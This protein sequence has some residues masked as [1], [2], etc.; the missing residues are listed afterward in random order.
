MAKGHL[1]K[2]QTIWQALRRTAAFTRMT[3][4]SHVA[5]DEEEE[6]EEKGVG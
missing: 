5:S 6:E 4:V 2:V 3:D 1:S